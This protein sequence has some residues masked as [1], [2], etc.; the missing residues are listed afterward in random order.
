MGQLRLYSRGTGNCQYDSEQGTS[1]T[2]HSERVERLAGDGLLFYCDGDTEVWCHVEATRKAPEQFIARYTTEEPSLDLLAEFQDR[3][4]RDLEALDWPLSEREGGKHEAFRSL[5]PALPEEV[6]VL[7]KLEEYSSY[8][9]VPEERPA[10]PAV[11][12]PS[13]QSAM[14]LVEYVREET[15]LDE[16]L[17]STDGAVDGLEPDIRIDRRG[18]IDGYCLVGATHDWARSVEYQLR[19]DAAT[20]TVQ[21]LVTA[22]ISGQWLADRLSLEDL[23]VDIWATGERSARASD[24]RRQL[25]SNTL[26]LVV[27]LGVA[28]VVGLSLDA[29]LAVLTEPAVFSV[30][31]VAARLAGGTGLRGVRAAVPSGVVVAAGLLPAVALWLRFGPGVDLPTRS[32]T[33]GHDQPALPGADAGALADELANNVRQLGEF[34][35]VDSPDDYRDVVDDLLRPAF[36]VRPYD[37]DDTRR[38]L[39]RARAVGVAGGATVGLA[40][41]IVLFVAAEAIVTNWAA[42][43]LAGFYGGIALLW[44]FGSLLIRDRIETGTGG[45]RSH[46]PMSV[47]RGPDRRVGGA[48]RSREP[49]SIDGGSR[50][51]VGGGTGSANG[52]DQIATG[53]GRPDTGRPE[54]QDVAT[55]GR[56]NASVSVE[57]RGG[58]QL[59]QVSRSSGPFSGMMWLLLVVIIVLVA[60]AALIVAVLALAGFL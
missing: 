24:L 36:A 27:A 41:S 20:S 17:V 45:G 47:E 37:P 40:L 5:P 18:D 50:E 59:G 35:R 43:V 28:S 25:F 44:V 12:A 46:E 26:L 9:L 31:P 14:E 32:G 55:T 53:R 10:V 30:R 4:R 49:G 11:G 42:V 60:L 21:D 15:D 39:R 33:T 7:G 6:P 54:R 38:M 8:G 2:E 29:F 23:G 57:E 3:L 16:I 22:D 52:N 34:D 48:G 58:E 13:Y 51:T 56:T 1:T 19:Y